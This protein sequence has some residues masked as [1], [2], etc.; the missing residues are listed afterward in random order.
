VNTTFELSWGGF[1]DAL[2]GLRGLQAGGRDL[3]VS[4]LQLR[5]SLPGYGTTFSHGGLVLGKTYYYRVCAADNV[6]NVSTGATALKKVLPEYD[7]PTSGSV[8]IH[9]KAG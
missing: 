9:G 3:G 7:P 2:S 1:S 8:I 6:G 5:G 4:N